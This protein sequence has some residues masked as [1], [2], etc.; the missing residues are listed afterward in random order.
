MSYFPQI[1][2]GRT[3]SRARILVQALA[4]MA[5]L[6][7]LMGGCTIVSIEDDRA[8]RARQSDS[9]D[10]KA[11]AE[12]VWNTKVLTYVDNSAEPVET[13]L[14]A[15]KTHPTLA[16]EKFGRQ[17][18]EG[19]PFTYSVKGEGLIT[20][21]DTSNPAGVATVRIGNNDLLIQTGPYVSGTTLR[22]SLA[23]ISFNDFT[24]Q[25]V[26]ADVSKSLNEKALQANSTALSSL[27]VGQKI[28]FTGVFAYTATAPIRMTPVR[29][30]VVS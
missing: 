12:Q 23:F 17:A 26:Y 11:Y 22:D 19:S 25:L 21:I 13:L 5:A 20:A 4:S 30:E 18:G 8:A 16:G 7:T 14:D 9:F 15:I 1:S 10:A 3:R 2:G 29:L 28:R 6:A 24:N 27:S